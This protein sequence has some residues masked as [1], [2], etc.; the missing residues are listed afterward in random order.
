L[1]CSIVALH[2]AAGDAQA[3]RLNVQAILLP[4]ERIQVESWFSSGEPAKGA[5]VCVRSQGG[6]VLCQGRMNDEGI[7]VFPFVGTEDLTVV[8][9]AGEGHR[10]E[11]TI[12]AEELKRGHETRQAAH[13]DPAGSTAPVPLAERAS[14]VSIKDVLSGIALLLALAGFSLSLRNVRRI[15]RLE[16]RA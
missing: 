12:S 8:V 1:L 13:V 5:S 11:L 10:K 4:D 2:L 14:G 3:H 6:Q 15:R 16:S 9:S 7:F